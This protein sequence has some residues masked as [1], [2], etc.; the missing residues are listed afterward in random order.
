MSEGNESSGAQALT[1]EKVGNGPRRSNAVLFC[2]LA[3]FLV[4]GQQHRE[5]ADTQPE[6][7]RLLREAAAVLA[8]AG[9]LESGSNV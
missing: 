4:W 9:T 2:Q 3:K 1:L 8:N 5:T 7:D 6:F